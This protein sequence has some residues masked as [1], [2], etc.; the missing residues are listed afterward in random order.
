MYDNFLLKLKMDDYASALHIGQ[1]IFNSLIN[2]EIVNIDY[3]E[4]LDKYINVLLKNNLQAEAKALLEEEL[5]LPYIPH[6][7][8][9]KFKDLLFTITKI[10]QAE[11]SA[12]KKIIDEEELK[13]MILEIT[14]IDDLVFIITKLS[15]LNIRNFIDQ[16]KYV[17]AS[18]HYF[19]LTKSMFLILLKQQEVIIKDLVIFKDSK[20]ITYDTTNL[21]KIDE[22]AITKQ[23]I[24]LLEVRLEKY[25]NLL[26]L[27]KQ[28]LQK[29]VLY[30]YPDVVTDDLQERV[31][32]AIIE[33]IFTI[34][35][36]EI[37]ITEQNLVNKLINI[38]NVS[39]AF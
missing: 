18:E 33:Y 7:Y 11:V 25:P 1:K 17:L 32:Q 23:M 26:I 15:E 30:I 37:V 24:K 16:I 6:Q 5:A 10:E 14:T 4:F 13:K 21:L 12:T 2:N 8:E 3:Y 28:V 34:S 29:Y 9:Q 19:D 38:M 36:L 27:A 35:N 20:K 22:L 31:I 39:F